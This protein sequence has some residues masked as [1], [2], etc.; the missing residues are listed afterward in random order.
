M[1]LFLSAK[2]ILMDRIALLF[3]MLVLFSSSAL[4][5]QA[6][7][8]A[9]EVYTLDG[10]AVDIRKYAENGKPTILS[11]WATWCAPCKK[12]LDAI[13]AVYDR[14]QAAY[15]VELLAISIDDRRA[16]V[17]VARLTEARKWPFTILTDSDQRLRAA[18]NFQA[19]PHTFLLDRKGNIVYDHTGYEAGDEQYLAER[20]AEVAGE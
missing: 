13:T 14:W 10:E 19:I 15:E 20:L 18:L 5:A 8:P 16:L 4:N 2:I 17:N 3:F 12:E 6:S 7:L 1:L 11:F 9:I